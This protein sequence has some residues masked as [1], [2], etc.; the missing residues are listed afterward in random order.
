M[1]AMAMQALPPSLRNPKCP[2]VCHGPPTAAN[3][4]VAQNSE[5][6]WVRAV[7]RSHGSLTQWPQSSSGGLAG[8]G[9]G[10]E[11][12][13]LLWN[14]VLAFWR[15]QRWHW[16]PLLP[17]SQEPWQMALPARVLT[18]AGKGG[19]EGLVLVGG[20]F[21]ATRVPWSLRRAGH[22]AQCPL[23]WK[24]FLSICK[25][26]VGVPRCGGG[27]VLH[28][29]LLPARQGL[30][31]LSRQDLLEQSCAPSSLLFLCSRV[32]PLVFEGSC[33]I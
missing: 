10:K 15:R 3:L 20:C 32:F 26:G 1:G 2:L 12:V 30:W 27:G 17:P 13:S 4:L 18:G 28:L 24:A 11:P 23:F 5:R 16:P 8:R 25:E 14:S 31:G 22:T 6:S 7:V 29:E 19:A 33:F 9:E 21:G